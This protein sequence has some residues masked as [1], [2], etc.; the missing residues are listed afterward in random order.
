MKGWIFESEEKDGYFSEKAANPAVGDILV[1][2]SV[3][4]SQRI[5][6]L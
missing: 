4:R 3:Y 6:T 1:M 5:K 2:K